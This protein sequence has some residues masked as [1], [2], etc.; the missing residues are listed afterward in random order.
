M[1]ELIIL[2]LVGLLAGVMSGLFGIGGGVVVIPA[3]VFIFGMTQHQAQGTSTALLLLPVGL[4]AFIN[5]YKAGHINIKYAAIIACAFFIGAFFGSK[6][7]IN[8]SDLT[9]K[10]IF[11]IVMILISIKMF[12]DK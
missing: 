5:Y 1:N 3:L 8:M 7:A 11:A 6:L 4:L 12:F 2:I 10:R 9:L